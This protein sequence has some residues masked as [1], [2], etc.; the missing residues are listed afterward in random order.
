MSVSVTPDPPE[1]ADEAETIIVAFA[2]P[3]TWKHGVTPQV[4]NT[5]VSSLARK[6][7]AYDLFTMTAVV[8]GYVKV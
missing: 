1:I 6:P 5:G 2:V 8:E 4:V 3:S 7:V